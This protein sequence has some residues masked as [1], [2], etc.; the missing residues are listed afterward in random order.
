MSTIVALLSKTSG[1]NNSIDCQHVS[2]IVPAML[3][4]A[5]A[6]GGRRWRSESPERSSSED[7]WEN[8]SQSTCGNRFCWKIMKGFSWYFMWECIVLTVVQDAMLFNVYCIIE[9]TGSISNLSFLCHNLFISHSTC[10][11]MSVQNLWNLLAYRTEI[12]ITELHWN[13]HSNYFEE[14][15]GPN[16]I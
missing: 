5:E 6:C 12:I 2:H 1:H 10:Y 8:S 14:S 16:L 11:L 15:L 3:T 13:T 9:Y 7:P 4:E